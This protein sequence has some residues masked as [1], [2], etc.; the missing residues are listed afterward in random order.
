MA[1]RT[2]L[3]VNYLTEE[4]ENYFASFPD[5]YTYL[6][7][8]GRGMT[9][10]EIESQFNISPK[11]T[12]WYLTELKTL[13]VVEVSASRKARLKISWPSNRSPRTKDYVYEQRM[14][15]HAA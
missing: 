4:Q 14:G 13:D 7:Y 12:K 5:A 15:K 10:E 9:P 6:R 2:P 1:N 3:K 8:L 11:A